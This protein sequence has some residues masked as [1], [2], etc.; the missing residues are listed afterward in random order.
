MAFEQIIQS[1]DLAFK[2]DKDNDFVVGHV[3]GR[4]GA[5]FYL[6]RRDKGHKSFPETLKAIRSMSQDFPCP[7][8]LIEDKANGPAVI[9]TLKNEIPGLIPI[10]PEGGKIARANAVAPYVEAGNVFLPNPDLHPWALELIEEAANFPNGAHDDDVDTMTQ[11]LRRLADSIAQSALPEFRVAPRQNDPGNAC[12]IEASETLQRSL[13]AHWRRW[14]S[15]A[16]GATGAALWFC[17]TP[18]GGIRVYRELN[19]DGVDAHEAGRLIA[20]AT[21]PDIRAYQSSVHLTAK[22]NV[23]VLME[24]AAFDPVEPIG[25]YAELLESGMLTFEPVSGE[26][27]YREQVKAEL[28][29]ARFS[30]NMAELEDATFDRLRD[31]MRFKPVDFHPVEWSREKAFALAEQDITKYTEWMAATEG[32]APENWPRLKFSDACKGVISAIG[33]AKRDTDIEDPY[34]RALIIGI[35]APKSLMEN[36]PMKEIAWTPQAARKFSQQRRYA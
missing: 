21:L 14:I 32:R 2:D 9:A 12:H 3:W 35:A 25:C 16:P 28:K 29:Q 11:A 19:L 34:L 27:E 13:P 24:K 18:Q 31:L 23:E 26:W 30:L 33:A 4:V 36:K 1:W 15:V 17:E 20:E 5:N 22:W 10:N 7:E 8:K 6:L